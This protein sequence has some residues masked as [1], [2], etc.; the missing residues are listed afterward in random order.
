MTYG[1]VFSLF[2]TCQYL[3]QMSLWRWVKRQRS[4][5]KIHLGGSYRIGSKI[6]FNS[7]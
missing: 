6:E 3:K 2:D 5:S 4:E 1:E 7:L